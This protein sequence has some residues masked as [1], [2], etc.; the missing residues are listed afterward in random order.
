MKVLLTVD[1]SEFS[2]AAARALVQQI[3]PEK[4]KVCVL[5]VVKPL[6][7]AP[8]SYF[9]PIGDIEAVEREAVEQGKK[10]VG[11]AQQLLTKAGFK[12]STLVEKGE[13]RAVI[14]DYAA[15]WNADLIFVG[16]HGRTGLDRLLIGSV[17][18]AV[19]RHAHCSV[20]IVRAPTS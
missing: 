11:R 20:E 6:S 12:T 13:P 1:D 2:E 14:V 15:H 5:H 4:T 17:S 19:L 3:R 16:S 8:L 7:L 10:L 18:E 9:G